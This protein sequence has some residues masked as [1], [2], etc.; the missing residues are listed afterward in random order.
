MIDPTHV[1]RFNG[2]GASLFRTRPRTAWCRHHAVASVHVNAAYRL[3]NINWLCTRWTNRMA[4]DM[5]NRLDNLRSMAMRSRS[6]SKFGRTFYTRTESG[7]RGAWW[8][9]GS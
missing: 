9:V 2:P 4:F 6:V 5:T 1:R 7:I 3:I 8:C